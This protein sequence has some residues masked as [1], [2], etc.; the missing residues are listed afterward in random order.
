[1]LG[2]PRTAP[3]PNYLL[4]PSIRSG[5]RFRN[6][7]ATRIMA[8]RTTRSPRKLTREYINRR[9]SR[10]RYLYPRRPRATRWHLSGPVQDSK[11]RHISRCRLNGRYSNQDRNLSASKILSRYI[12]HS[13]LAAL[14]LICQ[15][16]MSKQRV[17]AMVNRRVEARPSRE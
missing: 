3:V 6:V 8:N 14:L 13:P 9:R 12:E 17:A 15:T 7:Q 1:M 16:A 4:R 11:L 10:H 2:D 5:A